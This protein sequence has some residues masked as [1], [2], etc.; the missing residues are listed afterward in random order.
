DHPRPG[1]K[2][3]PALKA[4]TA[5]SVQI[6]DE[7]VDTLKRNPEVR[8]EV[9]GHTDGVG[10]ETYNQKLS[11]RRAKGVYDYLISHGVSESQ[12]NGYKGFGK[13]R[14]IDTNDTAEGRQRNRRVELSQ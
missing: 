12:I 6:L 8:V 7:A 3:V 10:T 11:E 1:E 9:D 2:L 13:D 5:A 14:P 4:P